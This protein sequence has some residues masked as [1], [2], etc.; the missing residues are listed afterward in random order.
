VSKAELAHF[1]D[2]AW[3]LLL[4]EMPA[5]MSMVT[6]E[7]IIA[8]FEGVHS[9]HERFA[10][11]IDCSAVSRFPGAEERRKLLDWMKEEAQHARE[12]R[13]TIGSAV[14]LTSGTMRALLS[15]MNW[16]HRPAAPQVWKATLGEAIE[17]GCSRLVEA[18]LGLTPAITALRTE[19]R[20]R[21]VE[22]QR[23]R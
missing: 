20:R 7:S 11:V 5:A 22:P 18:G 6:I 19:T 4:V 9:R 16:V 3:P 8:G 2:G 23:K 12:R 14:V 21:E 1:G 17:W 13:D 10:V 15:A